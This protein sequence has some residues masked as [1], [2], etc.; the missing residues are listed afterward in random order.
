MQK[1]GLVLTGGTYNVCSDDM[2][3]VSEL[4]VVLV[5]AELDATLSFFPENICLVR[6]VSRHVTEW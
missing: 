5:V 3:V 1:Q 2:L 6:G 4:M